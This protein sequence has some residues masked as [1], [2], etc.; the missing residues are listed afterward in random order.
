[1]PFGGGWPA[2]QAYAVGLLVTA[3]DSVVDWLRAGQAAQRLQLTAGAAWLT[4]RCHA[5]LL[6]APGLREGVRRDLCP[7]G[8]PQVILEL[9]Q[10]TATVA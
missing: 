3:G 1:M 4:V 10:R 6:D 5:G 7:D 8:V 2:G 9:G